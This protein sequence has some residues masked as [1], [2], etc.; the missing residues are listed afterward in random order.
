MT[1]IIANIASLQGSAPAT[2]AMRAPDA[3]PFGIDATSLR[4]TDAGIGNLTRMPDVAGML[5]KLSLDETL[6]DSSEAFTPDSTALASAR[7]SEATNSRC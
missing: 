1:A 3:V 2:I 6:L 4:S 5:A 7:I